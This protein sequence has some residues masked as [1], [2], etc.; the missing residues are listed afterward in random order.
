MKTIIAGGREVSRSD[1]MTLVSEA[2]AASGWAPEISEIVHGAFSGID[3]AA[4]AYCTGMWP[5]KTFRA[6][7]RRY[8]KPARSMRNYQM[9]QYA[10]ALIAIWNG[11]S[12]GTVDIITTARGLGLK[13]F[14]HRY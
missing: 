4:A 5:V 1:G 7:W 3:L 11:K 10:D 9:A 12:R 14:V 8:G 13:V 6:D 2:I